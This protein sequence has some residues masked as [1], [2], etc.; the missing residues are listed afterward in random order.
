MHTQHTDDAPETIF[1]LAEV[2]ETPARPAESS[3]FDS[4]ASR[5]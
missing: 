3:C 1:R 4:C 2:A 5:L